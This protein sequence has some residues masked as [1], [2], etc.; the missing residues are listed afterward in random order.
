MVDGKNVNKGAVWVAIR[1]PDGYIS[2]HANQAESPHSPKMI[3]K[4]VF[5]L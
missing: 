2:G 4:T 1:I 3:L 5:M